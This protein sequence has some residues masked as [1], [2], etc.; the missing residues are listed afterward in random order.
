MDVLCVGH[1]SWDFNLFLEIFPAEN[2]KC[3][4]RATSEC[5]GGPAANAA[6]LLTRW[7]IRCALAATIGTDT[8]GER[9]VR[10]FT[11]AGT[12]VSLLRR[13]SS[14]PTPVSV[15]LVNQA[16]GSRTIINRPWL[17]RSSPCNSP[18]LAGALPRR[19]YCVTAMNWR[20]RCRPWGK[21]AVAATGKMETAN[22]NSIHARDLRTCGPLRR[23]YTV[24]SL[25]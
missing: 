14:V 10:E 15:I 21:G 20:P 5:G 7:G 17:E 9:I 16:N 12:D 11:A 6:F 23:A 25:S 4:I 3:E 1:A 2:S 19:C 8:Y 18:R 22:E 13:S 24:G